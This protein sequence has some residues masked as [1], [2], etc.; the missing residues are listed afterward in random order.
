MTTDIAV[1]LSDTLFAA[2]PDALLLWLDPDASAALAAAMAAWAP[3]LPLHDIE[4][5]ILSGDDGGTPYWFALPYDVAD[6]S[7]REAVLSG[8][9]DADILH[10]RE[11]ADLLFGLEGDDILQDVRG[12]N[13]FDGGAGADI[14]EGA[15]RSLYIGGA[16]DDTI[17]AWG[18]D[19]T[20]A[21]NAGDGFDT[22][23]LCARGPATISLGLGIVAANVF[24][25]RDGGDLVVHTGA[26]EGMALRGWYDN[27]A[28]EA[29]SVQ[30]IGEGGVQLYDLLALIA[31][32]NGQQGAR[33][34]QPDMD[35]AAPAGGE[36]AVVYASNAAGIGITGASAA[37]WADSFGFSA[38]LGLLL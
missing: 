26:A 29:L 9:D 12:N 4:A 30:V 6:D 20:L 8:S 14:I 11:G 1:S 17:T 34:G 32:V 18:A 21:F 13:L 28:P 35:G 31:G 36:L 10:G 38:G 27:P 2:E 16:G 5:M 7:A 19:F 25:S 15:G 22:V 3:A 24:V 37:A 23:V 33:L